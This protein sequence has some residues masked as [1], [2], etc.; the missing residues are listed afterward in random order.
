MTDQPDKKG[1]GGKGHALVLLIG[2]WQAVR[3]DWLRIATDFIGHIPKEHETAQFDGADTDEGEVIATL[4]SKGLFA[5]KKAVLYRNP[6]FLSGRD[7]AGIDLSKASE[8]AAGGRPEESGRLTLDWAMQAARGGRPSSSMLVIQADRVDRRLRVF[9]EL[10]RL[11]LLVDRGTGGQ[12]RGAA[13]V[14]ARVME[15]LQKR[16]SAAGKR[17]DP[18][19]LRLFLEKVGTDS[20]SALINEID[21]LICLAGDGGAITVEQV[22]ELVSRHR[23]EELYRLTDA[24]K[25]RDLSGALATLNLILAQEIHPLA[26]LTTLKNL[27]E[28]LLA[29][30][31]YLDSCRPAARELS[32][33]NLFKATVLEGLLSFFDRPDGSS[34]GLG[35]N[36]LL[37]PKGKRPHPYALWMDVKAAADFSCQELFGALFRLADLDLDLKGGRAADRLL[38]EAFLISLLAGE[39]GH[40]ADP[41]HAGL[42]QGTTAGISDSRGQ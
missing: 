38:L 2:D 18:Q 11:A 1:Q 42:G 22:A 25:R 33:F 23:Q 32:S 28:R 36:P 19:G 10:S 4:R 24:V 27:F 8:G 39:D 29:I 6:P 21:K 7:E 9:K 31:F 17:L 41:L 34:D 30:R 3:E 20:A 40:D 37:G 14:D 15:L 12:G 35:A 26:I 16:L 13:K 5:G